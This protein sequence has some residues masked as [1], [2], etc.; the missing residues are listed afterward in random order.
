MTSAVYREE[1]VHSVAGVKRL[2]RRLRV[3]GAVVA[4]RYRLGLKAERAESIDGGACAHT[5]S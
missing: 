2:R 1:V 3:A 4:S 5:Y